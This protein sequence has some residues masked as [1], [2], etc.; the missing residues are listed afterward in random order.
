MRPNPPIGAVLA[1]VAIGFA[2]LEQP[3]QERIVGTWVID[4]A[5]Q[6]AEIARI[7]PGELEDFDEQFPR[8]LGLIRETFHPDGR[9]EVTSSLGGPFQDRWELVSRSDD[10]LRIRS[11]GH[12]WV[13]R[14]ATI[15][16]KTRERSPSVLTYEFTDDDH[17][18]VA[19][20]ATIFGQERAVR[21]FFMRAE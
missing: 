20:T 9:Y 4:E 10:R 19:S 1:A 17:M 15:G 16:A 6:R 7:S 13:A 2:C 11:S 3:P 18:A 21:Y 12:S 5:A 8:T 14:Q